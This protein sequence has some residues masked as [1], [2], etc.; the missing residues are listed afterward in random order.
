MTCGEH[1]NLE[2]LSSFFETFDNVGPDVNA[3]AYYVFRVR[4]ILVGGEVYFKEDL[5]VL[6]LDIVHA[7]DKGF[8]H[9]K[10]RYFPLL[11]RSLW[12]REVH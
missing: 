8:I 3:G 11:F 1:Y 9:I 7:M 6:L 5:G 10:Y 12:W 4:A 2:I